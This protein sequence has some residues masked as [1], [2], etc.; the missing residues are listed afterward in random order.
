M[1]VAVGTRVRDRG[2][3]A[4]AATLL[5]TVF[6]LP[7]FA[8]SDVEILGLARGEHAVGFQLLE[9]ED[10]SRVV[11]GGARGAAHPRP[12]R[13]YLW[14]PAAAAR[15]W[16]PLTFDRYVELAQGD[17]WPASV[18]GAVR[19]RLSPAN[20]PLARSLS[21]ESYAA[22]LARPMRATENAKP[23]VG[24]FPLVV[25]GL[26]LYYESP[27][28]FSTTAEY[29]A[30]HG[31][32]V[33]T[34]PL[35][36]THTHVV[37]LDTQDL[38]T[39]V[40][41]LE[42]AIAR[43]RQFS[44]VS[45]ERLGVFGFDMGGMAGVVLAMRNRDVDA[46]VSLDSGIQAPHA[47][48]LP[49]SSS[50]YDPLALRVPW[51]HIA[52]PR[53]DQMPPGVE[54]K[55]LFDEA[56]HADRYV[57]NTTA[58]GHADHTSYGLVEGRGAVANYWQPGTP[59]GAAAH[60]AVAE[61]V[62]RFFAAHLTGGS[63]EL[64][65]G[66]VRQTLAD[67]EATLEHGTAVAAPIGYDELVRKLVG[68]QSDEAIAEL[69]ALAA[70]SPSHALLTE[71]SLQRLAVSLLF[72]WN[73]PAQT[74]PLVEFT[75]ELYPMSPGVA[76]MLGEAQV[77]VGDKAAAIATLER[78]LEQRPNSPAV[79]VRLEALRAPLRRVRE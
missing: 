54:A 53:N 60:R 45:A 4:L 43:A 19:E 28:T 20:G 2:R 21:P 29:L 3:S 75:R 70:A 18:N 26:G 9:D 77:L 56:V 58:L 42:F 35:V 48:G 64:A 41:D 36:G 46:F 15:R 51:M 11:T 50:S 8:Q 31:F 67:A 62:R 34:A 65:Q 7:T 38:E 55:R 74:L 44:F 10:H 24:P 32:A 47:S 66:D 23:L 25:I 1:N 49:R 78:L 27:V 79:Q 40:R 30:G 63:F 5:A 17:I 6:A 16:Q 68:G 61:Y 72:S 52:H 14:Y 69:R 13:T 76:M 37:K 33:V 22:L 39:Q 73:L 59:A 71:F 57:I 12:M